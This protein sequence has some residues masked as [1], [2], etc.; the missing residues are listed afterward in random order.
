M[1]GLSLDWSTADETI[2]RGFLS[3]FSSFCTKRGWNIKQIIS[4]ESERA[5]CSSGRTNAMIEFANMYTAKD[6]LERKEDRLLEEINSCISESGYYVYSARF[7]ELGPI[8]AKAWLSSDVGSRLNSVTFSVSAP[9]HLYDEAEE[10]VDNLNR[11]GY[12]SVFIHNELPKSPNNNTNIIYRMAEVIQQSSCLLVLVD[13]KYGEYQNQINDRSD[14]KD[15]IETVK[16]GLYSEH[17][18]AMAYGAS[19]EVVPVVYKDKKVPKL[20]TDSLISPRIS[21]FLKLDFENDLERSLHNLENLYL[22][23]ASQLD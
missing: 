19:K 22:K 6:W 16:L 2:S 20:S 23:H 18:V 11:Y 12:N 15:T 21:Y 13:K 7:R 9:N 17:E 14:G 8:Q 5:P 1:L 10:L 4:R 3:I